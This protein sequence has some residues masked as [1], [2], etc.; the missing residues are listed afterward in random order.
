MSNLLMTGENAIKVKRADG[1]CEI[2]GCGSSNNLQGAHIIERGLQG[3]YDNAGNIIITCSGIG[4][5]HD[6][7]KYPHGLPI[8]QVEALALVAEKNRERGISK[9]LTGA[10]V[11]REEE[12]ENT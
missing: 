3:G 9:Y 5:C 10:E 2:P 11:P 8:S 7:A 1:M 4:G 6:H 12:Y